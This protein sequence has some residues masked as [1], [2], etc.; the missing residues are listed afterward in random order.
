MRTLRGWLAVLVLCGATLFVFSRDPRPPM[1]RPIDGDAVGESDDFQQRRQAWMEAMHAHAPD[2]DWRAIDAQTRER[3]VEE[4]AQQLASLRAGYRPPDLA[5]APAGTW[6][7]RGARNIAGRVSGVDYDAATDRLTLFAHGGQLWRSQR[8]TLNWHPL[9]DARQLKP[10]GGMQHF[11]RL[12]GTTERWLA[13]DDTQYGFFYSDDQ[14]ASWTK[15]GGYSVYNWYEATYLVSRNAGGSQIYALVGDYNF[16]PSGGWQAR[17]IVSNDRGTTFSDLGFVGTKEKSALF[18]IGQNTGLV[19]LLAGN[20]LKRIETNN[21]LTTV[22]TIA[23]TPAQADSDN[24]TLAGGVTTG[25]TPT[26]YLFAFYEAGSASTQVFRSLDAGASWT[27]RGTAPTKR[28]PRVA[29][30][31]SLHDPNL[32][33]YGG[34]NLYRST[35]GGLNFTAVNDWTQYYTTPA[36]V[37]HADVNFI[38]SV[39]DAGGNE[40][41]FVGT[42][43][44]LYESTDGLATTHNLTLTGMRQ[45]QYYDSYTGRAPPYAIS[46][47]A[48]DQGYQR[49]P[50]A[51]SGI[52]SYTQPMSGDWGHLTSSNGG[53]IVWMVYPN[54]VMLD[55]SPAGSAGVLPQWSFSIHGALFLA[56]LMADPANPSV[57]WLGGGTSSTGNHVVK[58][59]WSGAL[60]WS[61]AITS[62]EGSYDFGGQV[63]ALA[64]SPQSP[65]TF[66][67]MANTG[68]SSASFFR[69]ATPLATWT[70]TVTTLPQGQFFYGNAIVPDPSR[71]NTIYVC[72]S[73]Y[74][75]HSVYVSTDNGTSFAPMDAGLP[76]TLVYSLAISPDGAHLFAAT[77]V[78]PYY[79]DRVGAAWV[80]IGAGAPDS[81]YWNVD[82]VAALRTARFSTYGRGLWDY[83]LGGGDLIFRDGLD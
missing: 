23:G 27:M 51:S 44:G 28:V 62:S 38:T 36:T 16:G 10:F 78:G 13:A 40:V 54:Q 22:T 5:A 81:T 64:S 49:N 14:G 46:I 39:A 76:P 3:R 57:V 19:Y 71:A 74:S 68:G 11:L 42:D 53:G 18:A 48:Q 67:A 55:P 45:S 47:G 4:H 50:R 8:A 58:L 69:T 30:G 9:N 7:E 77:E 15:S 61:S 20:V 65:S 2:V 80:D 83:D 32:V 75:G 12:A 24:V 70:K 82:Y 73:G 43:G 34:M 35:D 17:L 59:T 6:H 52:S 56:P 25:A 29:A 66:F 37:M 41:F 72:G 1:P 31:T 60:Q 33:F 63:A 26:P 21:T 79:Y